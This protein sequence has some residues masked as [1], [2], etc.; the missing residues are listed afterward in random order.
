MVTPS[1]GVKKVTSKE[2]C[3]GA[4]GEALGPSCQVQRPL[5]SSKVWT[6][7]GVDVRLA[8]SWE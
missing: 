6:S 1:Q 5:P 7:A 8:P 3:L 4:P 2:R